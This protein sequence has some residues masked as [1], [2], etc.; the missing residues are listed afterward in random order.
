MYCVHLQEAGYLVTRNLDEGLPDYPE[1]KKA[2]LAFARWGSFGILTRVGWISNCWQVSHLHRQ[3]PDYLLYIPV[4]H[5][6]C[7]STCTNPA[8]QDRKMRNALK[9]LRA[10]YS[11]DKINLQSSSEASFQDVMRIIL[12]SHELLNDSVLPEPHPSECKHCMAAELCGDWLWLIILEFKLWVCCSSCSIMVC[13]DLPM[14]AAG[15][16]CTWALSRIAT[17]QSLAVG[18][19]RTGFSTS[20]NILL[21]GILAN[22]NDVDCCRNTGDNISISTFLHQRGCNMLT[23]NL[24]HVS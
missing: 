12:K 9:R 16:S 8:P 20:V 18:S 23:N 11:G 5:L 10:T 21:A 15:S 2:T 14:G 13:K 4:V 1:M 24:R 6:Q 3:S 19:D 7:L 22:W 17:K